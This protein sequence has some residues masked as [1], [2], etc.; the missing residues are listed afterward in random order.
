MVWV[1][2]NH[3]P[4]LFPIINTILSALDESINDLHVL[5]RVA[6]RLLLPNHT[7]LGGP[8]VHGDELQNDVDQENAIHNCAQHQPGPNHWL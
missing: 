7:T 2:Y 1:Y 5:G 6:L 8:W 4:A 3:E